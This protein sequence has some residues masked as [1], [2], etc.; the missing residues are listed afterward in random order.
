MRI[1]GQLSAVISGALAAATAAG[2]L[3]ALAI[4]APAE[5]GT[6]RTA[7]AEPSAR[8]ARL[9]LSAAQ[10][11]ADLRRHDAAEQATSILT[12]IV[13]TA[14]GTPA[15][16][17][18]VTAYGPSGDKSAA[19]NADG[20]YFISGL[21]AGQYQLEYRGCGGSGTPSYPPEWYGGTLQQAGSQAVVVGGSS[22]QPVQSLAPVTLQPADSMLGGQQDA[23]L[24]RG[25]LI[26]S[27]PV[28]SPP[29]PL[30]P[31]AAAQAMLAASGHGQL[32]A[33]HLITAHATGNGRFAG[34][35]TSPAGKGL[36]GICVDAFALDD[37][38]FAFAKTGAGG[39]YRTGKTPAGQYEIMFF[40][41]CGN[42]GNWL[43][44]FYKNDYTANSGFTVVVV[45][46]GRTTKI[47]AVMQ[48]GAE[49][50]GTVTGAK[51]Q[52]LSGV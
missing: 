19:T 32:S 49:I 41:G 8:P 38:G 40:T 35:V 47:D 6:A 9:P 51:G 7:S 17:V 10:M 44:Q 16:S 33:A 50:S 28:G 12:G 36:K 45:K 13:R 1:R 37:N 29:T 43:D 30:S 22:L 11:R 42:N 21:R 15:E 26:A 31:A 23:L 5:A 52:K 20:R 4:T 24:Q 3:V 2:L 48:P 34:V 46:A 25:S 14:R 39:R 18:C 27:G